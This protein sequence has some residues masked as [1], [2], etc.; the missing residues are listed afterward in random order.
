MPPSSPCS[1]PWLWGIAF[2]AFLF[3]IVIHLATT[4]IRSRDLP[5]PP[6]PSP[7]IVCPVCECTC[8]EPFEAPATDDATIEEWKESVEEALKPKA[9]QRSRK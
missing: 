7:M 6:P 4:G 5:K 2:L 1:T 9:N 8:P 3:S